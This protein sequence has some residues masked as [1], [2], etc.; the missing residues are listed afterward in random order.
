MA[1]RAEMAV[2]WIICRLDSVFLPFNG[3]YLSMRLILLGW[4]AFPIALS[5][6]IVSLWCGSYLREDSASSECKGWWG[7]QKGKKRGHGWHWKFDVRIEDSGFKWLWS[8][9]HLQHFFFTDG[10]LCTEAVYHGAI[11]EGH[12]LTNA[13]AGSDK[14]TV[15]EGLQESEF[16]IRNKDIQFSTIN[17]LIFKI[18]NS[19]DLYWFD[20]LLEAQQ[21]LSLVGL[22]KWLCI[23]KGIGNQSIVPYLV[24]PHLPYCLCVRTFGVSVYG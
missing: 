5:A 22:W 2:I 11:G 8:W 3:R 7:G 19:S 10:G 6:S 9:S 12:T 24:L 1:L 23:R 13:R 21:S 4:P 15:H 16:G 14:W 18:R 20:F 17:C